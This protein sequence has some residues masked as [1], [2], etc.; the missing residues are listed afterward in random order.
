MT[1][2][3]SPYDPI[4][5]VYDHW[6]NSF[7]RP[8]NEEVCRL[9]NKELRRYRMREGSFLDLGSGTGTVALYMAER[10]WS[11]T[12]IDA[13]SDMI[14]HAKQKASQKDIAADFIQCRFEQISLPRRFT[15]IGSFYDTLNHVLSKRALGRLFVWVG[16]HLEPEGLFIF[17]VNTLDCYRVLW[18]TTSVGHHA[19]YT[20]ILENTFEESRREARSVVT[21]FGR[22]KGHSYRKYRT[23]IEERWYSDEELSSLIARAGM[24]VVRKIHIDLFKFREEESYK[25]WWV[26]KRI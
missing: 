11:V 10:G 20:L 23:L 8:Y 3:D 15:V 18:N 21:Y 9:L 12:G 13:S 7:D 4:A 6:Q 26:C 2:P 5:A 24:T 22:E 25:T 16:L 1:K 14:E 17:D 19:D